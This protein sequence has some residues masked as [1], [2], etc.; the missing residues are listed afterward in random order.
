MKFNLSSFFYL[1]LTL[2][3]LFLLNSKIGP[4]PPLAK[5]LDPFNGFWQQAEPRQMETESTLNIK[6]LT[7]KVNIYFD[8]NRIP[9]IEAENEEDLYF[10]QGFIIAR[11]RLW[12]LDFQTRFAAGR[13]SE[14]IGE[15][16][17]DLDKYNR[18]MGMGFGARN[19]EAFVKKDR[20]MHKVL[21]AYTAGINAYI[22]TLKPKDYPIEFKL[23]DYKPEN[24]KPINSAYLLKLMSATLAAASNDFYLSNA[25][26]KFGP[27]II[28]DLFPNYP[29]R[30]D[31]IIPTGTTWDFDPV[32]VPKVP[33]DVSLSTTGIKL[34]PKEEGLGSNNWAISGSK[35]S[36]GYPLL[37][38]DPHLEM[39]L[40][41][42]WYQNQLTAPGINV[43]G[44]TIPGSPG[45]I[46]GFNKDVAW[47]VT[48]VGSDV[49]DWYKITFK[50][51]SKNEYLVGKEW[52]KV[53]KVV[54]VI[55]VRGQ[56]TISETVLY[57]HH[58]PIVYVEG[59]KPTA[60][61]KSNNIPV[62]YALKWIA[63]QPS[64]DIK[65]F[66]ELNRAKNHSDYKAALLHYVAPAQNF[67]FAS[68]E[69]DI[70]ITPNGYF[71]LKWKGQ[72]KFL[73]DGSNPAHEWQGRVPADQNPTVKN[74]Q[75]GFVSSANQFSAD[76]TYPY[77]LHWEFTGYERG[78]RINRQLANMNKATV[79][80]F[81]QLQID[82]Y[83][84]HAENIKDV[85]IRNVNVSALDAREKKALAIIKDWT[86]RYDAKE[87]SPSIFEWWHKR[88]AN[89][90]WEDEFSDPKNPMVIPSRDRTVQLLLTD[91][92][93][94]WY[95]N[96][97]TSAMET[98]GEIV[99]TTFKET[100][101]SL[102]KTYGEISS[103]WE[104]GNVKGTN[105]AHLAK[106]AGFGT[107]TLY[108]GGSKTAVNAISQTTGPSWKMIVS[109]GD[110]VEAYG[111]FPGGESG[112]PGSFYYDNMVENWAGG[113]LNSLYF[114]EK[115]KPDAKRIKQTISLISKK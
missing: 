20:Q 16:A 63:H 33:E 91:D 3:I 24:W 12:Q 58:G 6:G 77:Y 70:A 51:D 26:S 69:N 57:T 99:T 44:V 64:N 73:L 113:K 55:K 95:D 56:A 84:I 67:I 65:T 90:I 88:L 37:A 94:K 28:K 36:T 82:N 79:D 102:F 7:G 108:T 86:Y 109:L 5:F 106:I 21:D 66:Y 2:I 85:L 76:T 23:L 39:T 40:P 19:M 43:Y 112:N 87:I 104:W 74:P 110:K 11:D 80:D 83:S 52:K 4:L 107:K 30:E 10:A 34:N 18:R 115:G 111:L 72:G 14:V 1:F 93:S 100:I 61:A 114:Y 81:R 46:I 97:K 13:L 29:F 59:E 32:P 9:H 22:S 78:A 89:G 68:K 101:D 17:I 62:G 25:L 8:E 75:R 48:N 60:F 49:L 31:P 47:G 54:E 71:P 45:V 53:K 38:N 96:I 15:K 35:T 27:E 92:T 98:K 42:I 50:D 105:I 103:K 41:A